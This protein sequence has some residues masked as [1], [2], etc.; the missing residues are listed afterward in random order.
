[1]RVLHRC[2]VRHCVN[3][4]HLWLGTSADNTADMDA[5]GRRTHRQPRNT[6]LTAHEVAAIR[7]LHA[8]GVTQA[9]L[10]RSFD[11][12]PIAI[13]KVVHRHTWREVVA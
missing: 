2:D 13:W 10:A 5:K 1:M 4:D 6:R 11:V 12:T 9:E 8:A 7:R 3:P